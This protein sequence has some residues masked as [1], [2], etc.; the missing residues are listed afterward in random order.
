[1][2]KIH[3]KNPSFGMKGKKHSEETKLK[4]SNTEKGKLVSEETKEK[5]RKVNIGKKLSEE[6]KRK[7]SENYIGMKGKK[8]SEE[9]KEKLRIARKKQ[10]PI[11]MIKVIINNKIY[12]SI[13]EA[14]VNLNESYL[15]T[16]KRIYNK[17]F[18]NYELYEEK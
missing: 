12:N 7:I 4:I 6:T 10:K 3:K 18:N 15:K 13:K 16:Y 2:S 9:T 11:K 14:S 1:M 8:H 5:L 17:N